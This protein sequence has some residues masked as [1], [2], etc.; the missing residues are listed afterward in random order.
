[1]PR[2]SYLA[3]SLA[4]VLGSL[5]ATSNVWAAP[6]SSSGKAP[7]GAAGRETR[8]SLPVLRTRK[9]RRTH[10]ERRAKSD[11][12][13]IINPDSMKPKARAVLDPHVELTAVRMKAGAVA[14][15]FSGIVAAARGYFSTRELWIAYPFARAQQR[16]LV[17]EC[18]LAGVPGE[19]KVSTVS[20]SKKG[21]RTVL[22]TLVI[23][24]KQRPRRSF[25]V[26][27]DTE[28]SSSP[29]TKHPF[30]L[31]ISSEQTVRFRSC[32]LDLLE[33]RP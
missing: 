16:D 12:A 11:T 19:L 14:M 22:D 27:V 5:T 26:L 6:E 29:T 30:L 15:S 32:A 20:L 21:D 25:A 8:R 18:Q 7:P 31:R 28:L 3:A 24:A 17:L 9:T 13:G 23:P 33:P 4:C 1:M 2:L 10:V